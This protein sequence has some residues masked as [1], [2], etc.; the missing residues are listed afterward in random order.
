MLLLE[1]LEARLK[2]DGLPIE[3]WGVPGTATKTVTDLLQEINEGSASIPP[4]GPVTCS[5]HSVC[6]KVTYRPRLGEELVLIEDRQE[7]SDGTPRRR[8][9]RCVRETLKGR[10]LFAAAACRGLFEELGLLVDMREIIDPNPKQ[11]LLAM[12]QNK[13]KRTRYISEVYPKLPTWRTEWYV[14]YK[15]PHH[16]YS[17]GGYSFEENGITTFFE[18]R[19][20]N[21]REKPPTE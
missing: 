4:T 14:S 7:F 13:G 9:L 15:M 18:W 10:E 19:I 2:S 20:H 5:R 8:G 16:Y 6:T 3:T 11:R 12:L 21:T 17:P 1:E